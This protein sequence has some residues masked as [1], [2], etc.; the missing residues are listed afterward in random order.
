MGSEGH[1]RVPGRSWGI[2]E[3][4]GVRSPSTHGPQLYLPHPPDCPLGSRDG[5]GVLVPDPVHVSVASS[6]ALGYLD[7]HM[8]EMDY[9]SFALVYIYRELVGALS[10]MV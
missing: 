8:A 6:A 3:L 1:F 9:S 10:T 7:V 2:E 4:L 5:C